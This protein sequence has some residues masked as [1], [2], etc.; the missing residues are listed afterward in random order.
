MEEL[1][2][3]RQLLVAGNTIEAIALVNELEEMSKKAITI[4]NSYVKLIM[5]SLSDSQQGN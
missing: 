5:S 1:T 2:Q 4:E 3:L